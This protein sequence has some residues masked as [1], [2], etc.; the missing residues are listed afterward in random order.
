[1]FHTEKAMTLFS[2]AANKVHEGISSKKTQLLSKFQ[3]PAKTQTVMLLPISKEPIRVHTYVSSEEP[4]IGKVFVQEAPV[5]DTSFNGYGP[6][7]NSYG[8]PANSYGPPA[9]VYGPAV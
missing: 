8:P 6:P 9:D 2:S 4:I 7:A 5:H 3:T 1:M